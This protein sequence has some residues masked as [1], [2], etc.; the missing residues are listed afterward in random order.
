M[1]KSAQAQLARYHHLVQAL[2][3][4]ARNS[5]DVEAVVQAVHQQTGTLFPA[6][7]TL[8][9]LREPDGHWRWELY[10]EDRRYTQRL[11]FYP[12]GIIESVLGGQALSIPDIYAY[13]HQHPVRMRRLVNDD[14]VILDVH[15]EPQQPERPTRSMLFVPLEV[16]GQRTGVLS[17]QSHAAAAFDTTDLEFLHLL[18]QHV[19]IALENA[20]LRQELEQL[21]RTD[22][23]TGLLNRRAFSHDVPLALDTARQEGRAVSLMMLDVHE[24]KRIN[25][26]F[27]HPVGDA[28]LA[29]LGQVLKQTFPVPDVAFRLSG[30]EFA[31]L[32]WE[33][34]T[35]LEI[36]SAR[37]TGGLRAADWPPGP[38]P[39]CL[40]GGVAQPPAAAGLEEWLSL[41]DARMYRAKRQRI[42]GCQVNWGLDFGDAPLAMT[43]H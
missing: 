24:F 19:S 17:I 25:D 30:D 14:Q 8:L 22:A 27:G 37:L 4:L 35:R 40:Q 18:A 16:R 36:L 13:L 9:A 20:A 5:H 43:L 11:P 31:V 29:T 2:A 7:V 23:L 32:V 1:P 33:P 21:T 39:I 10:E 12:E 28:V 3:A 6:Q 42:V 38:G 26:D 41:A 34:E 15:A